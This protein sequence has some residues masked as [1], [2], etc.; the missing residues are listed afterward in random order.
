M[1]QCLVCTQL[2]LSKDGFNARFRSVTL[3]SP[4]ALSIMIK[5]IH[6]SFY[7]VIL[8]LMMFLLLVA[9]AN[10]GRDFYELRD[11]ALLL[12]PVLLV[13]GI[14][15]VVKANRWTHYSV[16]I[17]CI[18]LAAPFTFALKNVAAHGYPPVESIFSV[19]SNNN[20]VWAERYSKTD[21]AKVK[22]GMKQAEI[23]ELLGEP[24][25]IEN[26]KS[27]VNWFYTSGP[28]GRVQARVRGSTHIRKVVFR[29]GY[30]I[31]KDS[32]FYID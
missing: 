6:P 24:L 17:V 28:E 22:A 18:I 19:I 14:V 3:S 25:V 27:G 29:S 30:V 8:F 31:S 12:F 20:T 7:G 5:K 32:S 10:L 2:G 26:R 11:L 23:V 4:Y 13:L 15:G 9:A 16:S 1:G 21:F